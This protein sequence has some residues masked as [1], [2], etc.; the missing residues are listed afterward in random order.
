MEYELKFVRAET[1]ILLAAM[2]TS[3]IFSFLI[4]GS[5]INSPFNYDANHLIEDT[6]DNV[7]LRI[8]GAGV[9]ISSVLMGRTLIIDNA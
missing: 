5:N 9:N 3:Y 6:V 8:H 4:S 2:E 7:P 1:S